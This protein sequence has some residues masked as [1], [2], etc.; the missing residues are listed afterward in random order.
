MIILIGV[1]ALVLTFAMF[2]TRQSMLGFPCGIF[3]MLFGADAYINSA[4]TWD[5]YYFLFFASTFGMTLFTIFAAYGLRE[6][7]DTG[8]DEDEFIDEKGGGKEQY[9]GESGGEGKS[10]STGDL[11][12]DDLDR[13]SKPS[14]RT[15]MLHKRANERKTGADRPKK[16]FRWGEFK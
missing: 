4:A 16:R 6:Q 11:P 10:E 14:N 5:I 3:W 8:T 2:S 9:Y 1:I 12:Q 15:R 13:P 7:K